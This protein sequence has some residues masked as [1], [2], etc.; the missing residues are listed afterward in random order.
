MTPLDASNTLVSNKRLIDIHPQPG[1]GDV[2][3]V[4]RG[5][6]FDQDAGNLAAGHMDIVR[7]LDGSGAPGLFVDRFR[8]NLGEK[9]S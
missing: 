1:D 7:R 9:R 6:A 5:S 8:H 3:F 2:A 4:A